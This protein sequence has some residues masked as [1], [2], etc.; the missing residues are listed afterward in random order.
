MLTPTLAVLASGWGVAMA[1]APA[2]QLRRMLRARTSHGVSLAYFAVLVPGFGLW[3]AYGIAS[4]NLALVV[5]NALALVMH[6]ATAAVTVSLR[7]TGP[8][9]TPAGA[10]GTDEKGRET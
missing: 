1:C 10:A 9:A 2:L 3:L 7:S 6:V 8:D 5:P 4:S